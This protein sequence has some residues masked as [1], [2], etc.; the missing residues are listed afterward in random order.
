M[1]IIYLLLLIKQCIY[2]SNLF[3]YFILYQYMCIMLN[4]YI[5]TYI[6]QRRIVLLYKY[7][8]I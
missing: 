1:I 5:D 3:N 4:V 8:A 6:V 2:L 7:G